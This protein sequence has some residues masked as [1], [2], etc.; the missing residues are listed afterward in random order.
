MSKLESAVVKFIQPAWEA[1]GEGWEPSKDGYI[2]TG[3]IRTEAGTYQF[4]VPMVR[5]E[6]DEFHKL[7]ARIIQ[8]VRRD[9]KDAVSNSD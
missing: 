4:T 8:R 7:V 9:I 5:D 1:K 6:L 3:E 2:V